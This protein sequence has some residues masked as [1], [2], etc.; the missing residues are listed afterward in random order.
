MLDSVSSA[1][2]L[3]C[4]PRTGTPVDPDVSTY[5]LSPTYSVLSAEFATLSAEPTKLL[6]GRVACTRLR[7]EMERSHD[8]PA[9]KFDKAQAR[10]IL[11]KIDL[12]APP[13]F[14]RETT[15]PDGRATRKFPQRVKS[16]A[17]GIPEERWQEKRTT[18]VLGT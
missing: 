13:I 7:H 11:T 15:M 17:T 3:Y 8:G 10:A 14:N 18:N 4:F 6:M 2:A 5:D 9:S 12:L 16:G 1:R